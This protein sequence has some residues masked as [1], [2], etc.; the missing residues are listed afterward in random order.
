MLSKLVK[1][2]VETIV[3]DL[4][5]AISKMHRYLEQSY[6]GFYC[7]ICDAT[8]HRYFD[9]QAEAIFY[10]Q[11]FCR[12]LLENSLHALN[13][14]HHN[15]HVYLNGVVQYMSSC[16]PRNEY[17][18][19]VVP[20]ML[21]MQLTREE[22]ITKNCFDAR[23][24]PDWF[25]TC[26]HVCRRFNIINYNSYFEPQPQAYIGL[27]QYLRKRRGL[28]IFQGMT[29]PTIGLGDL[30]LPNPSPPVAIPIPFRGRLL[31]TKVVVHSGWRQ[32]II[33]KRDLMVTTK[34][35][36]VN[37]NARRKLFLENTSTEYEFNPDEVAVAVESLSQKRI[38]M[39]VLDGEAVLDDR[40]SVFVRKGINLY[41]AGAESVMSPSVANKLRDEMNAEIEAKK[42]AAMAAMA[43]K[44]GNSTN[45]TDS[46]T[47]AGTSGSR[48]RSRRLKNASLVKIGGFFTMLLVLLF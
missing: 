25:K 18:E 14:M 6:K 24:N 44:S 22:T 8:K 42:K 33:P 36:R 30:N 16:N 5:D 41:T 29:D 11:E 27:T 39:G 13:Y 40:R 43:A 26:K 20:E 17:F 47:A 15:F 46:G 35:Q 21:S 10:S 38:I 2:R 45:S 3:D 7:T 32:S 4:K 23:N 31:S 48:K 19:T 1:F 12:G 37:Y 28:M 9:T 34:H